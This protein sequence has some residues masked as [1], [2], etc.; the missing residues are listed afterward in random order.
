MMSE[1]PLR[2]Y[3]GYFISYDSN[4]Y[5]DTV[6]R[7][8]GP[9]GYRSQ[10]TSAGR[11]DAKSD[12]ERA[13]HSHEKRSSSRDSRDSRRARA[14]GRGVR[15]E[16]SVHYRGVRISAKYHPRTKRYSATV[17]GRTGSTLAG[18]SG[19]TWRE[20]IEKTKRYMGKR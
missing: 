10:G 12:A 15:K 7:L 8:R 11:G 18:A 1:Y 19:K 13:V 17:H 14:G 9:N 3:P 2:R 4:R 20:A 5:G 6:W 16:H